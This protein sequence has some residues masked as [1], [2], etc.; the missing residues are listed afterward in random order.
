MIDRTL[1]NI[2]YVKRSIILVGFSILKS[3][4]T[5]LDSSGQAFPFLALHV[6]RNVSVEFTKTS[7]TNMDFL[8]EKD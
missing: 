4:D 5:L 3:V 1:E 8:I 6:L 2:K 7:H